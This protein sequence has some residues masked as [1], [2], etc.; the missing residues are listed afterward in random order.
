MDA[1]GGPQGQQPSMG[2]L[3][4]ER[5]REVVRAHAFTHAAPLPS[6]EFDAE[7]YIAAHAELHPDCDY[8]WRRGA[9][10]RRS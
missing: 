2:L 6:A 5:E 1:R 10:R 8:A 7:G 9:W 3:P 4:I